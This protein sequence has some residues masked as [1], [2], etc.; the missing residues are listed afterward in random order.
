MGRTSSPVKVQGADLS[1]SEMK[2]LSYR[3]RKDRETACIYRGKE[4]NGIVCRNSPNKNRRGSLTLLNTADE[5]AGRQASD[6]FP[7]ETSVYGHGQRNNMLQVYT[8]ASSQHQNEGNEGISRTA[9]AY[10]WSESVRGYSTM[11][12]PCEWCTRQLLSID[13]DVQDNNEAIATVKSTRKY[14]SLE[15]LKCLLDQRKLLWDSDAYSPVVWT[16]ESTHWRRRKR[17]RSQSI[18]EGEPA[19]TPKRVNKHNSENKAECYGV[20][21]IPATNHHDP[22][23]EPPALL[24][25]SGDTD[26]VSMHMLHG[27]P[28]PASPQAFDQADIIEPPTSDFTLYGTSSF[29]SSSLHIQNPRSV[30][31]SHGSC[32]LKE[33]KTSTTSAMIWD[34]DKSP[35]QFA[36]RAAPLPGGDCALIAQTLSAAY[37]VIMQPEEDPL[38]KLPK[39]RMVDTPMRD[40]SSGVGGNGNIFQVPDDYHGLPYDLASYWLPGIASETGIF[41]HGSYDSTEQKRYLGL[42]QPNYAVQPQYFTGQFPEARFSAGETPEVVMTEAESRPTTAMVSGLQEALLGGL[43]GFWRQQKLY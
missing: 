11:D 26:G 23:S 6:V 35:A 43:K 2:F 36:N 10:T 14:W 1:F 18:G 37:D 21:S 19:Q 29:I 3:A 42:P 17:K 27:Q 40:A 13:W 28:A 5:R 32:G 12:D 16:N 7:H 30:M 41:S 9:T 34:Y 38:Y 15:E 24:R 4:G 8:Y 22:A 33:A 20:I 31:Q 25:S 39:H